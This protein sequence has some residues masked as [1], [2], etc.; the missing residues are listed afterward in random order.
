MPPYTVLM[1]QCSSPAW[2]CTNTLSIAALELSGPYEDVG[3]LS[4]PMHSPCKSLLPYSFSPGQ[5][6]CKEELKEVRGPYSVSLS[7]AAV[8]LLSCYNFDL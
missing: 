2:R 3:L 8:H 5:P 1:L 4:V 7:L 6:T